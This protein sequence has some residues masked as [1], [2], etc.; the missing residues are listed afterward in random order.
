MKNVVLIG[1][2]G[3]GKSTVGVLLAKSL[4]M[5]FVDTDLLIQRKFSKSLC[6]I[7]EADGV[8]AFIEKENGVIAE[9]EFENSVIAT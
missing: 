8:D 7:I 1:M 5:S 2:P 4:V 9:T 3:S 6:D